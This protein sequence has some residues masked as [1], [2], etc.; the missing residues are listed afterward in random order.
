MFRVSSFSLGKTVQSCW[1]KLMTSVFT[2]VTEIRVRDV[3]TNCF[4]QKE[5]SLPHFLIEVGDWSSTEAFYRWN[6]CPLPRVIESLCIWASWYAPQH[7][8]I[9]L[10]GLNTMKY[11]VTGERGN[12]RVAHLGRK[13]WVHSPSLGSSIHREIAIFWLWSQHKQ[14]STHLRRV[15]NFSIG[16]HNISHWTWR[17][18]PPITI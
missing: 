1:L 16:Y 12:G 17:S 13:L 18:Y 7:H 6:L 11:H 14:R 15:A 10:I 3:R 9:G 8:V 4:R 2:S 5:R